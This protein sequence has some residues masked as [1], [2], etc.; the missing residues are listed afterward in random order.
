MRVHTSNKFPCH[1]GVEPLGYA[2]RQSSTLRPC[3]HIGR[4]YRDR[5]AQN[6]DSAV[7]PLLESVR[8][9]VIAIRAALRGRPPIGMR[10]L[11]SFY[12]KTEQ[13]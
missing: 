5:F 4:R 12:D 9:A 8:E 1:T 6:H 3:K 2:K 7:N 13:T 10:C 11:A